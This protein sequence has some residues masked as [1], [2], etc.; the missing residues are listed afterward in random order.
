[1]TLYQ[2]TLHA[3]CTV[4]YCDNFGLVHRQSQYPVY[5]INHVRIEIRSTYSLVDLKSYLWKMP[6]FLP[7]T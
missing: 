1:M 7:H 5:L 2:W 6:S 4:L 3:G